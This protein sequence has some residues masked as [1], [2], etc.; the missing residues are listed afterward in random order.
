LD[1]FL[2]SYQGN[3]YQVFEENRSHLSQILPNWLICAFCRFNQ[4]LIQQAIYCHHL[5]FNLKIKP[6]PQWNSTIERASYLPKFSAKS[7]L[8]ACFFS[9]PESVNVC[10]SLSIIIN[11]AFFPFNSIFAAILSLFLSF[12][13]HSS[14]FFFGNYEIR[15]LPIYFNFHIS[16]ILVKKRSHIL[17]LLCYFTNFFLII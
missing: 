5:L 9:K 12:C 14:I 3:I 6:S 4:S 2:N 10:Y 11:S 17:I 1:N 16:I 8:N 7:M 15:K 13:F